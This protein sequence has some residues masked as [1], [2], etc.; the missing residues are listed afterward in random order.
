MT[1]YKSVKEVIDYA[2][3]NPGKLNYYSVGIGTTSHLSTVLFMDVTGTKM[4]RFTARCRRA[5]A[6]WMSGRTEI[7]SAR[8]EARSPTSGPAHARAGAQWAAALCCCPTF[9]P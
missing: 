6:T 4:Q 2:K 7:T 8:W 5:S 1:P 9:R 3:A